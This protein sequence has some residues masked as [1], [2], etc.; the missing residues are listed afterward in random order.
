VKKQ[1]GQGDASLVVET[2]EGSYQFVL[3]V[4]TGGEALKITQLGKY[5]NEFD[6]S[7]ENVATVQWNGILEV[8]QAVHE[9][10]DD[11]LTTYLLE[12]F[13]SYIRL[14]DLNKNVA[15]FRH[16]GYE[17]SVSL[18]LGVDEPVVEFQAKESGS[19]DAKTLTGEQFRDL[20]AEAFGTL[21]L[22]VDD[23]QRIFIEGEHELFEEAVAANAGAEIGATDVGF[24][25]DA[26]YRLVIDDHGDD[27]GLFKLQQIGEDGRFAEFPNTYHFMLTEYEL[28]HVLSPEYGPGFSEE[29][30]DALFVHLEPENAI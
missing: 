27:S 5:C 21:G 19:S 26:Q 25:G 24:S 16:S 29:T 15:Q 3:E 12:E 20:F 28:L 30:R 9:A 23:R 10:I 1:G 14:Q 18:A 2:D 22:D 13:I 6:I 11:R 4:K 8:C 17:K 7:P